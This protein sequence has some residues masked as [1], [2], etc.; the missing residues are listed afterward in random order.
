[1][2]GAQSYQ[3]EIPALPGNTDDQ[4]G[5]TARATAMSCQEPVSLPPPT[6]TEDSATRAGVSSMGPS[7]VPTSG[8]SGGERYHL[9]YNLNPIRRYT[10]FALG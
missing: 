3:G 8:K 6:Q 4:D 2:T 1:M 10:D 5:S 7:H 9:R